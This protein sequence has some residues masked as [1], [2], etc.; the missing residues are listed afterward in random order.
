MTINKA[1]LEAVLQR[2]SDLNKEL[3]RLFLDAG[4]ITGDTRENGFTYEAVYEAPYL[5]ADELIRT[6]A[7]GRY[8]RG[9]SD[10]G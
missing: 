5:T 2:A 7:A 1:A 9:S 10:A 6:L 4:A 8:V 3:D